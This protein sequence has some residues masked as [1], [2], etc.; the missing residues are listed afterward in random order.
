MHGVSPRPHREHSY[1]LLP[2][3]PLS[4]HSPACIQSEMSRRTLSPH[5][6]LPYAC[7]VC[8]YVCIYVITT[9]V[10]HLIDHPPSSQAYLSMLP[11]LASKAD[12]ELTSGTTKAISQQVLC[13]FRAC[14]QIFIQN[15]KFYFRDWSV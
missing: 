10:C 8:M 11:P 6:I 1:H 13:F 9:I 5:K 3:P 4:H 15:C 7:N 12:L 2:Q 14:F